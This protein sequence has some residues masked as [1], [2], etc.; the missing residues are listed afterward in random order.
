MSRRLK[1]KYAVS[2]CYNACALPM[3]HLTLKQNFFNKWAFSPFL[4]LRSIKGSH[5]WCEAD[6]SIIQV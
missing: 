6:R 5:A 3:K 1:G 4:C 2:Y